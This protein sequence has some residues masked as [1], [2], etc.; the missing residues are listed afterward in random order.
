MAGEI[1]V[2]QAWFDALLRYVDDVKEDALQSTQQAVDYLHGAVQERARELPGWS[3]LA[4]DITI[5]S[6]DGL[7]WVGLNDES[8]VS[9]AF[10]LEYGDAVQPPSAL[11]R[12]LADEMNTTGQMMRNAH[13]ARYGG[14]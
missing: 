3:E 11:F 6:D 12:S 14:F 13:T 7:L 4:D 10:A 2:D 5:W 1:G 9:V 8:F